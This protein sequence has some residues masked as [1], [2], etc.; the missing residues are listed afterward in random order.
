MTENEQAPPP[1]DF[2]QTFVAGAQRDW[3]DFD[4]NPP[5][6]TPRPGYNPPANP[7]P[8]PPPPQSQYMPPAGVIPPADQF[9]SAPPIPAPMPLPMRRYIAPG[10]HPTW[11]SSGVGAVPVLSDGG[12]ISP[13]LAIMAG[14]IAGYMLSSWKGGIGTA[15][16]VVGANNLGLAGEKTAMR[17]GAAAIG[18]G[19]GGY[20]VRSAA[21]NTSLIPNPPKWL[22]RIAND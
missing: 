17:L 22:Q 14:G 5:N 18:L 10:Q 19:V 11:S 4:L 13:L 9:Q 20:L 21:K 15:M 8:G 16:M 7:K 2:D 6:R 1:L 3:P 12:A